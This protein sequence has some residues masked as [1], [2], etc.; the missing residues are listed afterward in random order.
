MWSYLSPTKLLGLESKT[1][2]WGEELDYNNLPAHTAFLE[3]L[4]P[5]LEKNGGI[6]SYHLMKIF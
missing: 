4:L 6:D 5:W 3:Y 2:F 1:E